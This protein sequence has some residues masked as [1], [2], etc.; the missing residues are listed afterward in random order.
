MAKITKKIPGCNDYHDSLIKRLKDRDYAVA[1]LNA[2]LEESFAGD[3]ESQ[4]VF[5]N[6]LKNVAEAQGSMSDLARRACIRRES[7]YRILSKNGNPELNSL[8]ALLQAMGFGLSV[9]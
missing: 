3:K 4:Q 8:A 9:N 6:A 7:L 1:Y 2:A 5:L